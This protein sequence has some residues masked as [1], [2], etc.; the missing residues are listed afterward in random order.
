MNGDMAALSTPGQL[1]LS[2]AIVVMIQTTTGI[3]IDPDKVVV[4]LTPDGVEIV[5]TVYFLS[6][7]GVNIDPA[8]ATCHAVQNTTIAAISNGVVFPVTECSAGHA[9]FALATAE[10]SVAPTEPLISSRDDDDNSS[11]SISTD[12]TAG[13]IVAIILIGFAVLTKVYVSKGKRHKDPTMNPAVQALGLPVHSQHASPHVSNPAWL[14]QE[15]FG[16][17]VRTCFSALEAPPLYE[18]VNSAPN[19]N[20]ADGALFRIM[21]GATT[22][23]CMPSPRASFSADQD[24]YSRLATRSPEHS[25]TELSSDPAYSQLAQPEQPQYETLANPDYSCLAKRKP[26]LEPSQHTS[27]TGEHVQRTLTREN[28]YS[29]L[30]FGTRPLPLDLAGASYDQLKPDLWQ[31]VVSASAGGFDRRGDGAVSE[32][33]CEYAPVMPPREEQS[34]AH[35]SAGR[36][37][38]AVLNKGYE[39]A[40]AMPVSMM[41][42]SEQLVNI[43][44]AP[45]HSDTHH[46]SSPDTSDDDTGQLV[47]RMSPRVYALLEEHE[48]TYNR[49]FNRQVEATGRYMEEDATGQRRLTPMYTAAPAYRRSVPAENGPEYADVDDSGILPTPLPGF[50]A[51]TLTPRTTSASKLASFSEEWNPGERSS[52][53]NEAAEDRATRSAAESAWDPAL[54]T[55]PGQLAVEP[56]TYQ[57]PD[58]LTP[59]CPS[60]DEGE[61]DLYA[62]PVATNQTTSKDPDVKYEA[63]SDQLAVEP[64]VY[65]NADASVTE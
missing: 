7:S 60:S 47:P 61:D 19:I 34:P 17:D 1:A 15:R 50:C 44:I 25:Q 13:I 24:S 38:R 65:D 22:P 35:G 23:S 33:G 11:N 57:Q 3:A 39:C 2:D 41:D 62:A 4:R 52:R 29:D 45:A 59:D 40:P 31:Q 55:V 37:D 26:K 6:G 63:V 36:G 9:V 12:L 10:P 48:S 30:Q 53:V 18:W 27:V 42:R 64:A 28:V 16:E 58:A 21:D 5:A 14:G 49:L 8:H 20:E 54:Y 43:D 46:S 51:P 32:D 56:T